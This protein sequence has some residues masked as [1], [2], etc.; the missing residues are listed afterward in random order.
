MTKSGRT[1]E[2]IYSFGPVSVH[3]GLGA[4]GSSSY[5]ARPSAA[6]YASPMQYSAPA[7]YPYA[8]SYGMSP[9]RH[10]LLH[11]S[12]TMTRGG[13]IDYKP[14]VVYYDAPEPVYV[15]AEEHEVR[16]PQPMSL[17]CQTVKSK[18]LGKALPPVEEKAN[19]T[20]DE[21]TVQGHIERVNQIKDEITQLNRAAQR[22]VDQQERLARMQEEHI[23]AVSVKSA[24]PYVAPLLRYQQEMRT[25]PYG[26][27]YGMGY[28]RPPIYRENE[29]V[30]P[31][32]STTGGNY[33][34]EP[35]E[36]STQQVKPSAP[37]VVAKKAD[38][39]P[40]AREEPVEQTQAPQPPPPAP[41]SPSYD[42]REVFYPSYGGYYGYRGEPA[43]YGSGYYRSE[44]PAL[45][46]SETGF[47]V[48]PMLFK[49]NGNVANY[50]TNQEDVKF[51]MRMLDMGKRMGVLSKEFEPSGV[52][53]VNMNKEDDARKTED[54]LD[55]LVS[56]GVSSKPK[57]K[58]ED[59]PSKIDVI[60]P[61]QQDPQP[62]VSSRKDRRGLVMKK[63]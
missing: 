38:V 58:K 32:E 44:P 50:P 61:V 51:F 21:G 46:R 26:Y 20:L 3:G 31:K 12:L 60:S 45:L 54:L 63:P 11:H 14:E 15:E 8:M 34:R 19:N 39:A 22:I 57:E 40:K 59:E 16:S 43:A 30:A 24:D 62:A 37:V 17:Y 33:R 6:A 52:S 9:H 35:S 27:G 42:Q 13:P 47:P 48:S 2:P 49:S 28:M 10:H 36:E 41:Y 23:A 53:P 4:Y 7:P 29:E 56:G 55:D 1:I 5:A 25:P 18:D